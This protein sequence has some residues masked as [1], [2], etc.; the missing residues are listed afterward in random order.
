MI[1]DKIAVAR[2]FLQ[3]YLQFHESDL[4]RL[5]NELKLTLRQRNSLFFFFAR[6]SLRKKFIV[7]RLCN[8]LNLKAEM[9]Y[10]FYGN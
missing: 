9:M 5:A 6:A 1:N 8:K 3:H 4:K 2:K 10:G 7:Q